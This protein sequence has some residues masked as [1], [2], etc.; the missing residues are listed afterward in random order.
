MSGPLYLLLLEKPSGRAALRFLVEECR[1]QRACARPR[2]Q[3]LE[4]G[5]RG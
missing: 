3:I 2:W 1:H 5:L 4:I